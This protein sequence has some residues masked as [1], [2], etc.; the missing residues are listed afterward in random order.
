M[1]EKVKKRII[2]VNKVKINKQSY[3]GKIVW[4]IYGLKIIFYKTYDALV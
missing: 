2:I 3:T 1:D 4:K